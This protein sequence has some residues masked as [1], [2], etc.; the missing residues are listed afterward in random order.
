MQ[1]Q[2]MVGP[3]GLIEFPEEFVGLV[4]RFTAEVGLDPPFVSQLHL[5][6][7][8]LVVSLTVQTSAVEVFSGRKG[9]NVTFGALVSPVEIARLNLC[10]DIVEAFRRYFRSV[11]G[12]EIT[13]ESVSAIV[14]RD[15]SDPW[16]VSRLQQV[17]SSL[18]VQQSR[19]LLAAATQP[20]RSLAAR[21]RLSLVARQSVTD[22]LGD[23]LR[24]WERVDGVL[25]ARETFTTADVNPIS[26][27]QLV[28]VCLVA[29]CV[30]QLVE[31][32]AIAWPSAPKYWRVFLSLTGTV[33]TLSVVFILMAAISAMKPRSRLLRIAGLIAA[34]G[35]MV[36]LVIAYISMVSTFR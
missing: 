19:S 24:Y 22:T 6:H 31:F 11:F 18:F 15:H 28:A 13:V 10:V 3:A 2:L 25:R 27:S 8:F 35:A 33:T 26:Y 7:G 9:L 16:N 23:A 34:G 29:V 32:T 36:A 20:F 4:S 30:A 12:Q 21:R 5:F 1:Q 17:F 14:Q